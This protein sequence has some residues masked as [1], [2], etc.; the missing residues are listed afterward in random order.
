MILLERG[1][2][3]LG[4]TVSS[5]INHDPEEKV[6]PFDVR[7][8]DFDDVQYRV[9]IDAEHKNILKVA[10]NLPCYSYIEKNGGK[11]AYVA[12]YKDMITEPMTGF[13][14]CIKVDLDTLKDQKQKDE[15][16]EKISCMKAN[17]LGGVFDFYFSALL[18]GVLLNEPFKFDLRADTTIFFFPKNDRVTI[19][20]SI[21]F[22]EKVDKAIAKIFMQEFV[23]ARRAQQAAPPVQWGV[24]PPLELAHYKI[25][26]PT[27]NLGFISFA[28]LKSHLDAGKKDRVIN[29]LQCFRNYL[30]YH[31]KCSK[32][33][34]HARMRA[35][36]ASLLSVL[37][38]AKVD[39][40]ERVQKTQMK[41][42]SGK[43]FNKN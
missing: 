2:R 42:I 37:N 38:R 34:F 1:N 20:F 40:D 4:E 31:I 21:D 32:S 43:T 18:K 19:V 16:V 14:L 5:K 22:K 35:R 28:V 12:S 6:E 36:V 7:L 30:Q 17:V 24:N 23:E 41:T 11:D 26:E 10:M 25:T 29:V 8:C 13:D 39:A 33:H 3:I 15:L 27:G 9:L